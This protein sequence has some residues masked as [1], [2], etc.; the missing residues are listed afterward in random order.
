MASE[1]T[2]IRKTCQRWNE[3]WQAHELTFSCFR[4]R[5]FLIKDQTREYL[6]DALERAR[7][8]HAFHLWAYVAMPDHV[9]IVMP[10]ASESCIAY[11]PAGG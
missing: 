8:K 9:P 7:L 2:V 4:R 6:A 11:S 10:P 3:P 5:P 1:R